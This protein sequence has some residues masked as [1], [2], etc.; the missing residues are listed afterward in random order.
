MQRVIF[1]DVDGVLNNSS[2]LSRLRLRGAHGS[3]DLG[4][5]IDPSNLRVL[6]RVVEATGAVAVVSSSW[7]LRT[8]Q[9]DTLQSAL[10]ECGVRVVGC[11]PELDHTDPRACRAAEIR[12]WLADHDADG[13]PWVAIDDIDLD[14]DGCGAHRLGPDHFVRTDAERGLVDADADRAIAAL[15]RPAPR[16]DAAGGAPTAD[17]RDGPG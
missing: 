3:V 7:R 15:R 1:V 8:S 10:A 14:C 12:K 5:L 4:Q 17:R 9:L 11:T 6:V 16:R 13:A 2:T